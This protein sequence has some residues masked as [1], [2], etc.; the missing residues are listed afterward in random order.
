ME[1]QNT[2][3]KKNKLNIFL[4]NPRGFCAG[5]E[6]AIAIVE[7]A[8]EKFGAPIYIK[9]EIVHNKFVVE[10]LRKKGAVFVEDIAEIPENSL[11]IYSAHGVSLAVEEAAAQK[12]LK[13]FDATCPLVKKVHNQIV[14]LDNDQKTIIMIGHKGHPEVIGTSG[15][16]ANNIIL[17][18]N[19]AD[20][21]TV[22]IDNPDRVSYITQTTL[23]IDDTKEIIK[24]LKKRFPNIIAPKKDDICYA[25]QNRQDAV[26]AMIP[27]I[28]LLLVIGAQ[29]SSNSNRL[30]D[31]GIQNNIASF[32]VAG[33]HEIKA[34]WFKD[35]HNI[36]LTA[37]ASAPEI[38]LQEVILFLERN[39]LVQ[40]NEV[41]GKAENI[42]FN[43]PKELR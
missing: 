17:V 12:N 7:Q 36:G 43:L 40:I 2:A 39:F 15:R 16:I 6:R 38:L 37:G 28:D 24:I 42:I 26:K 35:K 27:N 10:N 31:I 29:N 1:P 30:Y 34:E 5:V 4:A 13:I 18:E 11:T 21:K 3:T 23:S 32:L 8:L 33:A 9:H 41:A 20:A 19:I 25:T 14:N 22:V